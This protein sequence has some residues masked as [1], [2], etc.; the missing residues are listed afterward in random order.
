[1]GQ[2]EKY[3][4]DDINKNRD[5][6]RN[7][8]AVEHQAK[9]NLIKHLV[10]GCL[11]GCCPYCGKKA[12][13]EPEGNAVCVTGGTSSSSESDT[14]IDYTCRTCGGT[15]LCKRCFGFGVI[16]NSYNHKLYDCPRCQGS[17]G[18]VVCYGR[19]IVR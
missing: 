19:G 5:T 3:I 18:C 4:L 10:W 11:I 6:G 17:G 14:E 1:M 8:M 7:R 2:Y 16:I 9:K 13:S 15:G 12:S